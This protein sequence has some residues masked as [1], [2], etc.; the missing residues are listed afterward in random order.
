MSYVIYACTFI[1][2]VTF[3]LRHAGEESIQELAK[4]MKLRFQI[5]VMI[6]LVLWLLQGRLGL[7]LYKA[8]CI[9][10]GWAVAG[11]VWRFL[12]AVWEWLRGWL[13]EG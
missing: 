13:L 12:G 6:C 7:G 1:P 2:F 10:V 3:A 11:P 8:A 4:K 9:A 5:G